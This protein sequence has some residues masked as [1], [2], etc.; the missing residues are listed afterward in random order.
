MKKLKKILWITLI[1]IVAFCVFRDFLIQKTLVMVARQMTGTTVHLEKFSMSLIKQTVELRHL[2][3]DHPQGFRQEVMVDIPRVAVQWRMM[4]MFKGKGLSFGLIDLDIKELVVMKNASGEWNFNSLKV[5]KE[6]QSK[7]P[8]DLFK[9]ESMPMQFDKVRLNLGQVRQIE[10]DQQANII[11]Q[12]EI[13][14]ALKDK[15]FNNVDGLP[16]LCGLVMF[17]AVGGSFLKNTVVNVKGM[18]SQAAN[19]VLNTLG[20][21]LK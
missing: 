17:E 20:S 4:D 21:F 11:S 15:E 14:I 3:V 16:A 5:V 10:I 7:N 2:K 8:L 6:Q 12:K 18:S 9:G 19:G 13:N 1:V